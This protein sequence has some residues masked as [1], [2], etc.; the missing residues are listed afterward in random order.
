[1]VQDRPEVA[2][3]F[4][5]AVPDELK[6]RVTFQGHDFFTPQVLNAD[7]FFIKMNLHDWPDKYASQ[8]LRNLLPQLKTGGRILLCEVVSPPTHD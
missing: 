3:A 8:I 6:S 4:A 2:E 7:V 1:M 5:T